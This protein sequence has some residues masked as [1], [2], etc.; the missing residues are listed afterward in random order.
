MVAQLGFFKLLHVRVK[1][2]L[3]CEGGSIHACQ[4]IAFFIAVPIAAG[5]R[6][7]FV[8]GNARGGGHV[9]AA[10]KVFPIFSRRSSCVPT[11]RGVAARSFRRVAGAL[12]VVNFIFAAFAVGLGHAIDGVHFK[13]RERAILCHNSSHF[14][15]NFGEIVGA[16]NL[17]GGEG[18]VVVEALF[19]G[20]A[21]H[22]LHARK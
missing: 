1:L 7:H 9:R 20:W 13:A 19:H 11:Q 22:Q 3:G 14:L 5:Q 15:L 12:R 8:R 21:I 10:A 2:R 4:S 16:W 17:P 6:G 18:H